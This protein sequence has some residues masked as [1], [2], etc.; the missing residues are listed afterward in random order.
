LDDIHPER[1]T[2]AFTT[3]LL[4]LLWVLEATIGLQT[5]QADLLEEIVG[6]PLFA[7]DELPAPSEESRLAPGA[8]VEGQLPGIA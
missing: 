4:Q 5:S 3:E 1:W 6:A 8:I 7:G 2:A